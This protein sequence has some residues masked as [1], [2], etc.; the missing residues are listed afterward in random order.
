MT[1]SMLHPPR[2]PLLLRI[3]HWAM[4]AMVLAMLFIGIGMVSTAGQAYP[5]LLALHRPLGIAILLLAA[6]RL[7]LRLSTRAPPLPADLP[8]AQRI[9][10]K[11]SHILLYAAMLG[12]PLI[13]WAMLSAGGYPV[14][15]APGL[16]LPPIL[17]EQI[18][19]FGLLRRAHSL[20]AFAFFA[21]IL[22]HL[23]A[24]LIHALIRRD[25]V[26]EAISLWRSGRNTPE[27]HEA[28]PPS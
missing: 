9:A 5:E 15:L 18:T 26:F 22:A 11:G 10:A 24:A 13:G 7:A 3:I 1:D 17:P 23:T 12:M 25:G 19:L 2:F 20:I 6:F 14:Q 4:A 27:R 8:A 16:V 21:L 28:D